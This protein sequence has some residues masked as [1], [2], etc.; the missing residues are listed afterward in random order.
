MFRL[1]IINARVNLVP[2]LRKMRSYLITRLCIRMKLKEIDTFCSRI[3]SGVVYCA[4]AETSA[5]DVGAP[6]R[7][8]TAH[9]V[10][11]PGRWTSRTGAP[12]QVPSRRCSRTPRT[13][14]RTSKDR[15]VSL[16]SWNFGRPRPRTWREASPAS[17]SSRATAFALRGKLIRNHSIDQ[18]GVC[19]GARLF[20]LRLIRDAIVSNI[21]QDRYL[22]S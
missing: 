2:R 6:S 4:A 1:E 10:R 12:C 21:F 19:R 8:R 11:S 15:P 22:S 17:E 16:V 5:S 18:Q 3:S 13:W 20:E 9:L 14:S 7:S